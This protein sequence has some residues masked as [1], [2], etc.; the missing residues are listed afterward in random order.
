MWWDV[1]QYPRIAFVFLP[2][3]GFIPMILMNAEK[4]HNVQE[5]HARKVVLGKFL[6]VKQ[7]LVMIYDASF[8]TII[9]LSVT[10]LISQLAWEMLIV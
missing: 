3:A 2:L 1:A 8:S 7:S 5:A 9:I 4:S 6:K 10:L